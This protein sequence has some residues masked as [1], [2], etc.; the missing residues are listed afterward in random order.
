MCKICSR[1][2]STFPID[3][4]SLESILPDAGDILVFRF[5]MDKLSVESASRWFRKI[6]EAVGSNVDVIAIPN[7]CSLERLTKEKLQAIKDGIDTLLLQQKG[8]V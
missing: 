3:G 6:R 1:C 2:E 5:D 4:I 7:D 8:S